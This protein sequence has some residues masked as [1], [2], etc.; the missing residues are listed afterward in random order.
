MQSAP[1][2]SLFHLVYIVFHVPLWYSPRSGQAAMG[3]FGL[4]HPHVDLHKPCPNN[5]V[6][7]GNRLAQG[8]GLV[9]KAL[10]LD[11][12]FLIRSQVR[13]LTCAIN[14][15]EASPYGAIAPAL[16]GLSA[17]GR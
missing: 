13:N 17:C 2:L 5:V 6:W 12:C 4:A 10:D 16:I 7:F 3:W 1:R 14:S 9:V 15:F 8:I 11:V